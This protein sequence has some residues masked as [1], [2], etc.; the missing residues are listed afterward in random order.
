MKRNGMKSREKRTQPI[1]STSTPQRDP[2]GL[3]VEADHRE[4]EG[5]L[6]QLKGR[7]NRC[8]KPRGSNSFPIDDQQEQS[9]DRHEACRKTR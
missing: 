4:K 2:H 6:G 7:R 3:K 5:E 1:P 8:L 9:A